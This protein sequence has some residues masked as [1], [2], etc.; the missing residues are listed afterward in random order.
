M[1]R[2][3]G[4]DI[5]DKTIGVAVSDELKLIANGITTILRKEIK[6]DMVMLKEIIKEYMI[7]EI[8]V[9][10]PKNLNNSIGIQADKVLNFVD[11]LKTETNLKVT[12]WD[13][14]LSTVAVTRTLIEG[15][16]S[17]KKRKGVI[18][19]LAA[20]YILQGYLDSRI[21]RTVIRES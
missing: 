15:K 10:L 1:T 12:T 2:I 6:D 8:V 13:E 17:R 20:V 4:L 16:M 9:G 11:I 3:L 19:K 21:Q 7:E 18:D 14:R 5:G